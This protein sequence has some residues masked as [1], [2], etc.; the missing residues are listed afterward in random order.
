MT[1][2]ERRINLEL[3]KERTKQ[4]QLEL[5]LEKEKTKQCEAIKE[6]WVHDIQELPQSKQH[7]VKQLIDTFKAKVK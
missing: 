2:E 1:I 5:E 4:K 7:V 6:V 3:E